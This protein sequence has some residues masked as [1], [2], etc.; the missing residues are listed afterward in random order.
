MAATY[1]H[2]F[3]FRSKGEELDFQRAERRTC[4]EF[5]Y[6]VLLLGLGNGKRRY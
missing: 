3:T 2:D 1:L 6:G 5:F 4:F